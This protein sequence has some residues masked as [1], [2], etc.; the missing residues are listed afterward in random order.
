MKA[1]I[2]NEEVIFETLEATGLNWTVKKQPLFTPEGIE[3]PGVYG[4]IRNDNNAYIGTVGDR[5]QFVQNHELVNMAYSAGKEVFSTET[6][7]T[8]PWNN[9]ETL[10]NFGNLGGGSLRGGGLVF[11][12]LLLPD[13]Y[14]GKSEIKRYITLT[15][16]H[17]GSTSLGFGTTNQVVCCQNTFNIA[18]R[19][20][21]KF[22]HTESIQERINEAIVNIRRMMKFEEQQMEVFEAASARSFDKKHVQEMVLSVFGEQILKPDVST[23]TKNKINQ[24]A[25]DMNKSI[26][27][28]G[29][30][31][32]AL[33]NG[34]TRYAN[35]STN[36]K[37]KEHSLMFGSDAE[38]S[39]RAFETMMKWVNAPLELI[40]A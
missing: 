15:N 9:A 22:R 36:T 19:E 31:M 23:V 20:L 12:Q 29:E 26:D 33:F 24:L 14:V 21:T 32:W 10:G 37:D 34:V 38:I 3:A 11:I 18:N 6:D 4:A 1:N 17:D 27:E 25:N 8:H 5:Y 13:A 35:H 2:S 39:Q 40:E 30:T 28:Q 7:L 16:S